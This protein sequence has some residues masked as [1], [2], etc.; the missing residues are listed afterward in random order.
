MQALVDPAATITDAIFV[1]FLGQ[2]LDVQS[3][4]EA[5]F[6]AQVSA[7]LRAADF[8]LL[9]PAEFQRLMDAVTS[10]ASEE[11]TARIWER[12][13]AVRRGEL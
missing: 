9:S 11:M 5:K 12:A 13:A 7:D 6:I 4:D 3:R 1:P 2:V 8:A 10:S